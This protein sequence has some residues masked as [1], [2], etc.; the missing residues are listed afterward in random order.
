MT[1]EA[2]ERLEPAHQSLNA[3][4][5]GV[6]DDVR[7]RD[8]MEVSKRSAGERPSEMR[9]FAFGRPPRLVGRDSVRPP[10]DTVLVMTLGCRS[11][12]TPRPHEGR[13][14]SAMVE[15]HRPT[16]GL[17]LMRFQQARSLLK[18]H[19]G[20]PPP[21]RNPTEGLFDAQVSA[22]RWWASVWR[23]SVASDMRVRHPLRHSRLSQA[24]SP[25][26]R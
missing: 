6:I 26:R 21:S 15:G 20:S 5:R 2:L 18:R 13:R 1:E 12:N 23:C 16:V 7:V 8:P 4:G 25:Q 17:E 9:T 24:H 3:R 14:L 11:V 19:A 10:V 22:A